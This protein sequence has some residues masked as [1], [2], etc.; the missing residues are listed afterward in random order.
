MK[1]L[2]K[3]FVSISFLAFVPLCIYAENDAPSIHAVKVIINKRNNGQRP[4]LSDERSIECIYEAG[5]LNIEFNIPEGVC[6]L[7]ITNMVNSKSEHFRFDSSIPSTINI[8]EIS[9]AYILI[10]TE[11][12]QIYE[13]HI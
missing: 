11:F 4:S 5:Y 3:I 2:L 12:G 7:T 9:N 10:E 8:G 13:G 6:K 1:L